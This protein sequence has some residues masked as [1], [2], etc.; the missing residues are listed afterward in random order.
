MKR[1]AESRPL[2]PPPTEPLPPGDA[3]LIAAS[4]ASDAAAFA[5]LYERHVAAARNLARQLVRGRAEADDIVAEAFAKVLSQ[6]RSG[7]GPD[8]A[9]RPYLLTTVRRVAIDRLRAE[10]RLVVSAEMEAFD[11]GV[12]FADPA[13][14]D[15]ER[16][17]I[18]RAFASLPE[19]WRAVL[20]HTEIEGARPAEVAALLGLT[21]NG[22]AALAYRAREGLRQAYLQMHLSGVV[23]RECRPV[24]AK[25]GAYVRGGLAKRETAA[26]AAHL[27]QCAECRAV[28][29]EL[30]DVN[31]A[32]RGIVAP[33]ILGPAAAAYLASMSHVGGGVT[34]W[35]GGRLIWFRHA[36]KSQQAATAGAAAAGVAGLVALALALTANT[37]PLAKSAPR[38]V[39]A[40]VAPS[41]PSPPA[42]SPRPV[43]PPPPPAS[44]PPASPAPPPSR[45]PAA[46][47]MPTHVAAPQPTPP[48]APVRMAALINPVGTL[49][50]GGAGIVEFTVR[51]T[52]SRVSRQVTAT[53]TLPAGVSYVDPPIAGGW[54][55][56]TA[57][58]GATC[59]HGPLAPGGI[60]TGYLP[61]S[62]STDAP[63]GAPPSIVVSGASGS[64]VSAAGHVGV[65][66]SGLSARFAAT[67]QDTVVAAGAAFS[68][69]H[70]GSWDHSHATSEASLA[71]P[72]QV[73]WAGL[74]WAGSRAGWGDEGSAAQGGAD[75]SIEL[76]GPGGDYQAVAATA[77]GEVTGPDGRSAFEAFADVTSLVG[78]YGAGVW[79]AAPTAIATPDAGPVGVGDSGLST[80]D[81]GPAGFSDSGPAG[82]SD[83]GSAG[84]SHPGANFR[85]FVPRAAD[86]GWTL[87]VVTADPTAA[88]GTQV[89]VLDGAHVVDAATPYLSVPLDGL[90]PG[91]QA[92][93]RTVTWTSAGPQTGPEISAFAQ[94]L[95]ESPAVN[96]T[97]G[98]VPYL[99]GVVAVTDPPQ[100]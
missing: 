64:V 47:P 72:G 97:A 50:R 27:D 91:Q 94:N 36:P 58:G 84:F 89:M 95:A 3:D 17:M 62:V 20:W 87:V 86:L 48:P 83:S 15:L 59:T 40:R 24:A 54:T 96:F 100:P 8:S 79:S 69:C 19:R 38:P 60:A 70:W 11:P 76:R 10:G 71:L 80:R 5:S 42:A 98:N 25:L 33:V 82:F 2:V 52:G 78:K 29:L 92:V 65:A 68:D 67:G 23:R 32:L 75:Q 12:A 14:A 51:N 66:A 53:I 73:L 7:R 18:S 26:V 93:V 45:S 6:L 37:T 63:V 81:S 56:V 39:P 41:Q 16:T 46:L 30:A 21:A 13:V 55:C 88:P 1:S 43:A 28:Y 49:L 99:V 31:V 85:D 35:I 44:P 34:G 4:R 74:Y 61:V 9:F 22:V 77:I 90:P 57:T